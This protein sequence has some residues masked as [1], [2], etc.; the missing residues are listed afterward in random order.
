M[1]AVADIM[2]GR[3]HSTIE[4]VFGL[5]GPLQSG[6]LKLVGQMAPTREPELPDV[7][8]IAET[9][10][11]DHCHRIHEPCR[12]GRNARAY[13]PTPERGTSSGARLAGRETSV[14]LN[15]ACRS[16]T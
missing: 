14:T 11:W 5:R 7:P 1:A 9:L 15:L 16:G 8:A 6:D 4:S 3:V 13:R 10:P 12:S 2:G